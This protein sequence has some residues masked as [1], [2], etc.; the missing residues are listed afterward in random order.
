MSYWVR[1]LL[2]EH[3]QLVKRRSRGGYRVTHARRAC[4]KFPN[5]ILSFDACLALGA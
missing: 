2:E 1:E 3:V 5:F 4:M